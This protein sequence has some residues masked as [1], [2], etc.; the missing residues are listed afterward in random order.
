VAYHMVHAARRF[1]APCAFMRMSRSGHGT[2][3]VAC[4]TLRI[5]GT[6]HAVRR[7]VANGM[8][9]ALTSVHAA[10]WQQHVRR[11]HHCAANDHSCTQ[12]YGA[13]PDTEERYEGEERDEGGDEL[14]D[15]E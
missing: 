3:Y 9:A 11:T 8:C 14:S 10:H 15:M 7:A 12:V 1:A 4:S 5:D 2:R 6:R 13:P